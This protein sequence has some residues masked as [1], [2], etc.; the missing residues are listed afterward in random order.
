MFAVDLDSRLS[1][2]DK[3]ERDKSKE[4]KK[5][6]KKA[7]IRTWQK[8]ISVRAQA[9]ILVGRHLCIGGAPDVASP[10][11]S[12]AAFED[13]EGG[14]LEVYSKDDGEQISTYKLTS[15]PIYD[16]MAAAEGKLFITLKN[17]TIVC[18]G[19]TSE[20]LVSKHLYE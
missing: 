4:G 17:G 12:W 8:R 1:G 9:M 18:Y 19:Q 20:N 6:G 3:L 15:A 10:D 16:G 14:I 13:C 7:D 11:D 2:K 5:K